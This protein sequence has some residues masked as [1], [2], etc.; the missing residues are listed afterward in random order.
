MSTR[1]TVKSE[2]GATMSQYD[3]EVEKRLKALE[4]KAHAKCDGGGG[5]DVA[6]LEA[7]VDD[8]IAKLKTL[9]TLREVL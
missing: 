8:L 4:S 7:K 6:A 2:S 5:G 3:Q 9:R 1:K